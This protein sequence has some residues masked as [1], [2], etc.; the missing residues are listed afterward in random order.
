MV[1][2]LPSAW[3]G[4]PGSVNRL[5]GTRLRYRWR[6]PVR[7]LATGTAELIT[8]V[9]WRGATRKRPG[10]AAAADSATAVVAAADRKNV[11]GAAG[12]VR[13]GLRPAR[14]WSY[15]TGPERAGEGDRGQLDDIRQRLAVPDADAVG[16]R[17]VPA[18]RRESAA[19]DAG[20]LLA[21][22]SGTADDPPTSPARRRRIVRHSPVPEAILPRQ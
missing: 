11:H 22:G 12:L 3:L 7:L 19:W 17:T 18:R 2:S 16:Q 1:G 15:R 13:F 14:T 5:A 9:S 20:D 6:L 10:F 21:L 4:D 8:A